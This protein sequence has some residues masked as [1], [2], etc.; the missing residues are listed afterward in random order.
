MPSEG[1]IYH[2]RIVDKR[3]D[4]R[5]VPQ[6]SA[7]PHPGTKRLIAYRQGALTAAERDAVQEHLSLCPRCTGMLRELRTFEADA[8][9]G[10]APADPDPLREEAWAALVQRLPAKS[11]AIRP[12]TELPDSIRHSIRNRSPRFL[13]AAV[14]ALLLVAAGLSGLAFMERQRSAALERRL[15]EREAAVSG[16]ERSLADA[17]RQL[18]AARGRIRDLE[19]ERA[20]PP[21]PEASTRSSSREAEL[22][23]RV[24]ELTSELEELRRSAETP[25]DRIAAAEIEVSLAPRFV[26]RG[27]E[28]PGSDLLLG[29]GAVNRVTPQGGSF[30]AGMSLP[31]SPLYPEIRIELADRRSGKVVWEG[32][33][34][35]DALLGDDGASITVH[36][37]TPGRYRLRIEGLQSDRA[38]L[39]AE[40]LLD[41]QS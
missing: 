13:G 17:S 36:G 26:L 35:G 12:V 31:D 23:A 11:P 33:Q 7:E 20:V 14:A 25:R 34:P 4:L 15:A 18:D 2:E 9:D 1:L 16:I 24:A 8:A 32:R 41:V 37:L 27:Q 39:L 30:T 28:S 21:S 3:T 19:T 22:A 40:Y 5:A 38:R 6:G 29:G 10:G